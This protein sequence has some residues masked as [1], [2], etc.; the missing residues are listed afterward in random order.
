MRLDYTHFP[1]VAY[2]STFLTR[3]L[4]YYCRQ[5]KTKCL[6]VSIWKSRQAMLMMVVKLYWL[7][8]LMGLCEW[9][10]G[11]G[12]LKFEPAHKRPPN[13]VRG[14]VIPQCSQQPLYRDPSGSPPLTTN[15]S[16]SQFT[17][18]LEPIR[19]LTFKTDLD[20]SG[21]LLFPA[22]KSKVLHGL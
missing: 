16:S 18:L 13:R 21:V 19:A 6:C 9:C 15:G 12:A 11:L 10:G 7:Q 3:R 14:T 2:H 8:G 4:V 22:G 1:D 20:F 5:S 17:A